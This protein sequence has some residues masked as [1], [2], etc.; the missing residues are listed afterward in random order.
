LGKRYAVVSHVHGFPNVSLSGVDYLEAVMEEDR[1]RIMLVRPDGY[2]AFEQ[3]VTNWDDA[4]R[5]VLTHLRDNGIRAT[6]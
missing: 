3:H 5:A 2:I 4:L 6:A 1:E